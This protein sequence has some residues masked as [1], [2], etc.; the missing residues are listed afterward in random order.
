MYVT[1]NVE[2]SASLDVIA[3]EPCDTVYDHRPA[4]GVVPVTYANIIEF[5]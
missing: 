1:G 5:G 4:A 3:T 2:L